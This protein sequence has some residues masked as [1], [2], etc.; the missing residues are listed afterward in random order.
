MGETKMSE[1]QMYTIGWLF[2]FMLALLCA[3]FCYHIGH[4][5]AFGVEAFAA[6]GAFGRLL[7][8]IFHED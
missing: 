1:R 4:F 5:K 6:G 3:L 2:C 8:W 7:K